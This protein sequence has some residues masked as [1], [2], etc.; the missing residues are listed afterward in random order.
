[1]SERVILNTDDEAAKRVTVTGWMARDGQW[2]GDDER[3]A[4]WAGSTH[5]LCACG[6]LT[7][8]SWTK[9]DECRERAKEE[10][11]AKL[12]RREWDGGMLYSDTL[13]RYFDDEDDLRDY[14]FDEG[15]TPDAL[16]LLLCEP[17]YAREIDDDHWCDDLP[18]DAQMDDV[19]GDI[20]EALARLNE[21]IRAQREAGRP[22]S[23]RPSKYAAIIPASVVKVPD[24]AEKVGGRLRVYVDGNPSTS[25]GG[26]T[27]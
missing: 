21:V 3:M 2:W 24:G 1:M 6:K 27:T 13:E 4:R 16:R 7:P 19:N 23:W 18:E 17:V 9:C 22:I 26:I 10:R 12:E 15:T 8:K 11:Y 20:A 25:Q 14:C 5:I